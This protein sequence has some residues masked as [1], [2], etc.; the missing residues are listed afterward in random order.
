MPGREES[1]EPAVRFEEVHEVLVEVVDDALRSA[2]G[3]AR[4]STMSSQTSRSARVPV[5][6][7]PTPK[8]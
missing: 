3:G 4:T 1:P 7:S 6:A 8:A 2:R 5:E